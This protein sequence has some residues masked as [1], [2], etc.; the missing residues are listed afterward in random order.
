[1]QRDGFLIN[2]LTLA[3]ADGRREE[4]DDFNV[5]DGETMQQA[6]ERVCRLRGASHVEYRASGF[7]PVPVYRPLKAD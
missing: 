5:E 1:M 7:A 6:Q 4:L 2:T 3:Y